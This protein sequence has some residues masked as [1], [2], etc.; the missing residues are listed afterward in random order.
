MPGTNSL[1]LPATR[2]SS[3][4]RLGT[5]L[6]EVL[7][8]VKLNCTQRNICS[9]LWR[10]TYGC[11]RTRSVIS[12]R[13]FQGACRCCKEYIAQQLK[14]LM[15]KRIIKRFFVPGRASIFFFNS[16]VTDWEEGCIDLAAMEHSR[17]SPARGCAAAEITELSSIS[18]ALV[19]DEHKAEVDE[20]VGSSADEHE[21]TD[22]SFSAGGWQTDY[23]PLER[24]KRGRQFGQ[25]LTSSTT[26]ELNSRTTQELNSRTTQELN[27]RTTQE[28]NSRTTQELNS[29]STP[30][31]TSS[32]AGPVIAPPLN[33]VLKTILKTY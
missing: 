18:E 31:H 25:E 20:C 3:L 13:E 17:H 11:N 26:Q 1:I 4:A 8:L 28:L 19:P 9:F 12:L 15:K 32:R 14:I 22:Y 33:T 6:R 24:Q 10:R 27:S 5:Q 16:D 30:I 21:V 29:S 23:I 2:A 7:P